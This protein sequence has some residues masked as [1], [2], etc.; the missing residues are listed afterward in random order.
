MNNFGWPN[1]SV[2]AVLQSVL[3]K[4]GKAP[5]SNTNLTVAQRLRANTKMLFS[6]IVDDQAALE[7]LFSR[8][9]VEQ[10]LQQVIQLAKSSENSDNIVQLPI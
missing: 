3:V 7:N 10:V 6:F 1:N 8:R 5:V 9:P 2:D 4:C